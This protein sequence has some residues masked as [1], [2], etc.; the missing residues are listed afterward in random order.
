MNNEKILNIELTHEQMK[1]RKSIKD[2]LIEI[3][4]QQE[5]DATFDFFA[6]FTLESAIEAMIIKELP[7]DR[8]SYGKS[9][10]DSFHKETVKA[11][12]L[13]QCSITFDFMIDKIYRQMREHSESRK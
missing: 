7:N 8:F 11:K 12:I 6:I 3:M 2:A 10:I 9:E 13:S 5:D 1:L 4:E